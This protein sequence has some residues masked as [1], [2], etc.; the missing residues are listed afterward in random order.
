MILEKELRLQKNLDI[1]SKIINL[2]ENEQWAI[3]DLIEII[4][5]VGDKLFDKNK[6][7]IDKILMLDTDKA[8]PVLI[9]ALNI[10]ETS[11]HEPCSVYAL[12]LKFAKKQPGKVLGLLKTALTND[13]AP[14]Y[15]L[16]E[17][18]KKTSKLQK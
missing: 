7:S 14:K 3:V 1:N 2:E 17:L 6:K 13:E 4:R 18:I 10:Y 9:E 12:I 5:N 16:E 15:Y 11:K 8:I